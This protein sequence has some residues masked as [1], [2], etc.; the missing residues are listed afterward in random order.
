MNDIRTLL[1]IAVRRI[2]LGAF[3]GRAHQVAVWF[4]AAALLLMLIDRMPA[5]SFIPWIWAGPAL[6]VV[7]L[8]VVLA[9]W[10]RGRRSEIQ[11]AMAVDERLDLRE[12]LSTAL[13]CQGRD[14]AFAQ[15]A[16]EDAVR[17]ARH[18]RVRE[19]VSRRFAV[20][21]PRQWW[22]TPALVLAVVAASLLPQGD[23]FARETPIDVEVVKAR[24]QADESI[25][26]V[27]KA[28][29]EQPQLS[30]ELSDLLGE[31]TK[32][33][34][35][36]D[37]L[38]TPEQVKR[39]AIKKVTDLSKRLDEIVNGEKG[40]TAQALNRALRQIKSPPDGPAKDLADALARGD[41]Q[42]AQ[43]ALAELQAKAQQGQL[44]EEQKQQAA[45]QLQN[46]AEQLEKLA[47]QQQQLE[48]ALK[49]AGLD[50][51]LAKNPQALQQALQDNQNLNDQQKQQLQQM[52]QAQ[53]AAGQMCQSLGQACQGMAQGMMAG[54]GQLSQAGQGMSQQLTQMEQMQMLLQQAQAAANACQGQSQGLGQGL[55][56]EAALQQWMNAQGGAFGK[57][58]RGAGGKAP[59]APTPTRTRIVQAPIKTTEGDIIARQLIDGPQFVGES[60][61]PVS[62]VVA[63]VVEG[64]D[65]AVIEGKLP[66]KYHDAHKHYFGELDARITPTES[67]QAE[68]DES[69][70]EPESDG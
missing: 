5:A 37:A 40:M 3:L 38:R 66:R 7:A 68:P 15:A 32:E 21:A 17:T 36:P 34:T 69:A 67:S 52:A 50:P 63:E 55:S 26:A 56:M 44:T 28:I 39:D 65:E 33:G 42:A 23:L 4:A 54:Q 64:Y 45:A 35:D 57:A 18:P 47:Q 1:R 58:G 12:K 25:D 60:K 2:E 70:D 10:A 29:E 30:S 24:K 41:F 31:L 61:R 8:A 53:Q 19:Q 49:Q 9:W 14:D 48:D 6:G 43:K 20:T 16:I 51:Q 22:M 27:I 62:E 11:V 13:H 59:I 46:I